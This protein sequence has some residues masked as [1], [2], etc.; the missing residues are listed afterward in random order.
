MFFIGC[1]LTMR[2]QD[3]LQLRMKLAI[4]MSE[5]VYRTGVRFSSYYW[6]SRRGCCCCHHHIARRARH[7]QFRPHIGSPIDTAHVTHPSQITCIG[8]RVVQKLA[9]SEVQVFDH[10]YSVKYF[11]NFPNSFTGT[12]GH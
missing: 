2:F 3:E 8:H 6:G 12:L 9:E 1:C 4:K 7:P 5:F 11:L 10:H